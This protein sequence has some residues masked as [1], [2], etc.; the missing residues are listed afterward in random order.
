MKGLEPSRANA[1]YVLNVARLPIPP[2]PHKLI[3]FTT[4]ALEC[5]A[6]FLAENRSKLYIWY[7]LRGSQ[8]KNVLSAKNAFPEQIYFGLER[9]GAEA[10]VDMQ[11]LF[12]L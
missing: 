8:A 11:V 7:Y 9:R 5:S 10:V 2:H 12:A 4:F 6:H 3:A 1:H